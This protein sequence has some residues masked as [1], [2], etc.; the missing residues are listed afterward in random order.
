MNAQQVFKSTFK[1]LINEDYSI[2][3]DIDR[4]QGV[5]ENAL[6]KIDFS[7]GTDIYMLPSNV[8][9][10]IGKT[11][12]YNNK[13]SISNTGMKICS[14]K[15][16]NKDHKKLPMTPLGPGKVEGAGLAAPKI[17]LLKS[18]DKPVNETENQRMLSEKH[19]DE[20]LSITILIVGDGL[21]AHHVW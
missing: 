11:V 20:K 2:S 19:N 5:L 9:L 17:H 1:A 6:S 8:N 12:G 13:I 18:T 16:I 4:Y 3:T 21:V 14:N 15:D 7:V 10:S